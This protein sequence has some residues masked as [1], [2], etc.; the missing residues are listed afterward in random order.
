MFGSKFGAC[1]ENALSVFQNAG[2]EV[3]PIWLDAATAWLEG[4]YSYFLI[5]RQI[6]LLKCTGDFQQGG[7]W[8]GFNDPD[9]KGFI[10]RLNLPTEIG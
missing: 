1:Q 4:R 10:E 6:L 7:D 9:T 2:C 8:Y 3:K 5:D